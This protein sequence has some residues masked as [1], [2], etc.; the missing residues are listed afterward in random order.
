MTAEV[1]GKNKAATMLELVIPTNIF[2]PETF[3]KR[4]STLSTL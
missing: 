3:D 1:F 4:L 2:A